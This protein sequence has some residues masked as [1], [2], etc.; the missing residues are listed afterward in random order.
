VTEIRA[1]R[2]AGA[3]RPRGGRPPSP[4]RPAQGPGQH[5][6]MTCRTSPLAGRRSRG[7]TT[8]LTS[9]AA[10]S[11]PRL[12]KRC[13]RFSRRLPGGPLRSP[14]LRLA[15]RTGSKPTPRP[16]PLRSRPASSG[17]HRPCGS[18]PCRGGRRLRRANG[19]LEQLDPTR[20]HIEQ[21]ARAARSKLRADD[22]ARAKHEYGIADGAAAGEVRQ[23]ALEG[24]ITTADALF[25]PW[26]TSLGFAADG[27]N[28]LDLGAE[29]WPYRT[30]TPSAPHLRNHPAQDLRR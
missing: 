19:E 27:P 3:V 20:V 12:S 28:W 18:R 25:A 30:S 24:Q 21:R 14:G 22:A 2:V 5:P 26:F 15:T 13:G 16:R 17:P 6:Q 9:G 29:L 10:R 7:C 1:R 4:G 8:S 23:A 11:T